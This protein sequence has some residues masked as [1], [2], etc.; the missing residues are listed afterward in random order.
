[1]R[2]HVVQYLISRG[3]NGNRLGA[4]GYADL[5]PVA[6]NATAAGR[7]HEP[8]R[9]DRLRSATTPNPSPALLTT[10]D[11]EEDPDHPA[12]VVLVGG[13][14]GYSSRCRSKAVKPKI[15]GTIYILPKQF[16][17]NLA[18]GQYATLTVALLLAPARAS[19]CQRDATRPPDRL[20]LADRGGR[21]PCD[22]H[23][24]T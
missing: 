20:R 3:V 11:E 17:L 8:P 14:A 1:M 18:G 5:H 7:A 21:D 16:T 6:T 23:Q 19:A 9:R 4:A 2:R 22:H 10:E 12:V 15:N 24:L 13:F